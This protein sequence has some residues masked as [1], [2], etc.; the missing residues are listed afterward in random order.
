M[1]CRFRVPEELF[2][3][4]GWSF[5]AK[6]FSDHQKD[7]DHAVHPQ[8]DGLVERFNHTLTTQL[9]I[10]ADRIQWDWDL[11]LV[12][13]AYWTAIQEST[14]CTPVALMFDHRLST[15]GFGSPQ[16]R[17]LGLGCFHDLREQL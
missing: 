8:R 2:S 10:L 13:W 5:E 12:L 4:Q 7:A 14:R 16:N 9:T 11:S 6:V 3:S 15:W 1:F 17:R